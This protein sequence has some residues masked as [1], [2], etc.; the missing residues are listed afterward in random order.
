MVGASVSSNN[1]KQL[2]SS[3]PIGAFLHVTDYIKY[4]AYTYVTY[5]A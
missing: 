2:F 3:L 5:L 4:Y 1:N